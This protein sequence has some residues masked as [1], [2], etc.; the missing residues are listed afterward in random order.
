MPIKKGLLATVCPKCGHLHANARGV[1]P[2]CRDRRQA[3]P[4][5][6]SP[7]Q[8]EERKLSKVAEKIGKI[9]QEEETRRLRV[10]RLKQQIAER[11]P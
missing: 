5:A 11:R 1:C 3:K 2:R 4:P 6:L 10:G 9:F 8:R 7:E